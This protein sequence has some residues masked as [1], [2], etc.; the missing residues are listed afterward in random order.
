MAA[1]LQPLHEQATIRV[2]SIDGHPLLQQGI[3]AV[4]RSQ[5]DMALIAG[6]TSAQDGIQRYRECQPDITLM[7][8]RLRDMSGI[9]AMRAIRSESPEARVIFLT[10]FEGDA[11]IER[12]L[13]AGANSYLLKSMS[14]MELVQIIRKVHAGK[15]PIPIE[16]A[17]K[18]AEHLAD[19]RLTARETEVLRQ[20]AGGH[21][22][23]VIADKLFISEETVKI[24]VKH[25]LD[26]LRASDRTQALAIA[27]R[28][29]MIAL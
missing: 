12:A 11:G 22:N 8:L 23:R 26:K 1:E 15:K 21:R 10:A 3:A 29:G 5:P 18:L 25:L 13:K 7:D 19:E 20:I 27:I 16:V 4:I 9:D 2:L 28:R 6:A 14:A 17:A 24:H